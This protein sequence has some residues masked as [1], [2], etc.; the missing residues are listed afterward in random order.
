MNTSFLN[1]LNKHPRNNLNA[2]RLGLA[3]AVILTHA[4]VL[5]YGEGVGQRNDPLG[6]FNSGQMTLGDSA[7]NLFFFLSGILITA[8]FLKNK[9]INIFL[10]NRIIRIYPAYIAS[11]IFS[12]LVI[13]IF[14]PDFKAQVGRGFSWFFIFIHDCLFLGYR[15]ISWPGVFQNNPF[16][17]NAN[18]S[19][20]TIP[21]EFKCYLMV[22]LIG[23]FG[24]FKFRLLILL[25]TL[26]SFLV[27]SLS[28]FTGWVIVGSQTEWRFLTYYLLGMVVWL[29]RDRVP[30]SDVIAM[31]CFIA[32]ICVACF[33]SW[34]SVLFLLCGTYL[35][36][37]L[38]YS[39]P[40]KWFAWTDRT[41]L[42][43]GV[44]LFAWPV[45][46]ILAMH[47]VFRVPWL[48]FVVA[49]PI[50]LFCAWLSW[51]LIEKRFLAMKGWRPQ[52]FDPCLP[53]PS[54]TVKN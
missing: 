42:S 35:T 45:Q 9:S 52:D 13:W 19:L 48:Q 26:F 22:A 38:G 37:W 51:T 11:L 34:F 40:L 33:A 7:V 29:W 54:D 44:Y 36:L 31:A 21:W 49:T 1:Q 8:S 25:A 10:I 47:E 39:H 32:L 14:C 16:P 30:F 27:Y 53:P 17:G 18:G 28:H 24:F 3:I 23:V 41:D 12:A 2:I 6:Y 5:S 20:W 50:A 43:Y 46:Q 4:F 15:S